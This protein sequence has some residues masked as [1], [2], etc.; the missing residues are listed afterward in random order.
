MGG[1]LLSS[2]NYKN[3]IG[4]EEAVRVNWGHVQFFFYVGRERRQRVCG[5]DLLP[6]IHQRAT[7]PVGLN[8]AHP[9]S[10][11]GAGQTDKAVRSNLGRDVGLRD[12]GEHAGHR[13]HH[14]AQV[15][16]L[17][18]PLQEA[19]QEG[20]VQKRIPGEGVLDSEYQRSPGEQTQR[21]PE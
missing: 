4:E 9:D 1:R 2:I 7:V 19:Q 11:V 8:Y 6:I 3:V 10:L 21:R 15:L 18:Q 16:L 12:P 14:R 20:G 17:S 13:V 5:I